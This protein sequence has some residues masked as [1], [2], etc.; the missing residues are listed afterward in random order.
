MKK[1]IFTTLAFVA[2]AFTA[3]AQTSKGTTLLGGGASFQSQDGTS[4]WQISPSIGSF[5]KDN[6]AIGAAASLGGYDGDTSWQLGAFVKPYFGKADNGK[7][8]LN[9]NLG[10]GDQTGSTEFAYGAGLGYASFLNKSIALEFSG[11]YNKVGDMKGMFGLG[12]GFQIHF[13]K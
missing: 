8:F 3:S 11:N 13:K 12:I 5:V 6:L 9:A 1:L 4:S 2:I 7:M 10:F